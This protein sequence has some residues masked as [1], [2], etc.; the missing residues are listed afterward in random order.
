MEEKFGEDGFEIINMPNGEKVS[1]NDFSEFLKAYDAFKET[2][3]HR[4]EIKLEIERHSKPIIF[5]EGDYDIRYLRKAAELLGKTEI[6]DKI[7]L[8][9]GGGFGGLDKVWKSYNNP[10]SKVV[11]NK[12][13]LLYDCDTNKQDAEKNLVFKRVIPLIEK[14]PISKGIENLFPCDTI[15]KIESEN[16]QYIDIQEESKTRVRGKEIVVPASKSVNKDEKSNMCTWLCENGTKE[17]FVNFEM[18][19]QIIEEIING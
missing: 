12:I 13:I 19:F 5:V 8:K 18:V 2:T 1:S 9:D 4:E 14:N 15:E 6:L 10:I 11:P 3:R 7:Q 17:D 16:P